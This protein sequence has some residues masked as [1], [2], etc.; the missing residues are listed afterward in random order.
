MELRLNSRAQ[1]LCAAFSTDG[2]LAVTGSINGQARVWNS[3]TGEL[4]QT[5]QTKHAVWHACFD[6]EGKHLAIA[7]PE[8][9][10]Q[11]WD[12][13]SGKHLVELLGCGWHVTFSP[14]GRRILTADGPVSTPFFHT[15]WTMER[16]SETRMSHL[17]LRPNIPTGTTGKAC[18]WDV[19][20]GR[21]ITPAYGT[22]GECL[23]GFFQP[24]REKGGNRQC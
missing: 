21:A 23:V 9:E 12:V 17:L 13:K 19:A 22:R 1:V 8:R 20:S 2:R 24:R 14:D 11:V 5:I 3:R 7:S 18:I 4:L 10:V 16:S 15:I 6:P